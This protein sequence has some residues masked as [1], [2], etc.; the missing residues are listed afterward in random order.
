MKLYW[1][2]YIRYIAKLIVDFCAENK[3]ESIIAQ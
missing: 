1:I 2:F 3:N